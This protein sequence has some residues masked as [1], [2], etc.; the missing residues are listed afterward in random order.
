MKHPIQQS[1][2][3]LA[4]ITDVLL[5]DQLDYI[6]LKE[7][8]DNLTKLFLSASKLNIDADINTQ[9]LNLKS[10]KAIGLKW[11]AMCIQ[12]LIRTKQ[13]ISGINKAI[14]DKQKLKKE[15]PVEILYTGTGPFAT[16]VMPLIARFSP[17]E[18]QFTCLE[19][20]PISIQSL[21]NVIEALNAKAYF[22]VIHECDAAQFQ[23][24][25]S[26]SLD[27]VVIEVLQMA[28]AREPQVAITYNLIPQLP[29]NITLIP[30]EITL[31]LALIDT[32]KQEEHMFAADPKSE[33]DYITKIAEVF[34]INKEYARENNEKPNALTFPEM[35]VQFSK[36]QLKDK[37]SAVLLTE[38]QIYDSFKLG[39][40]ESGLTIPSVIA[41]LNHEKELIGVKTQYIAN[42]DPYL[43]TVLI[44]KSPQ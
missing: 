9:H 27:I 41:D 5:N 15:G 31:H 11:A 7:S 44:R 40:R 28:L 6:T 38:I 33:V 8:L 43:N 30:K 19:V 10:G 34:T 21:K 23:L 1:L 13:F 20:N 32:K 24:P 14:L 18:I 35:E 26:I 37:T 3:N 4:K 25:D 29:E 22:R 16:L 39:L 36:D 17:E 2:D 12:D 42:H